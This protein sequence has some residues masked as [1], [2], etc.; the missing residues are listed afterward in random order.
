M[1]TRVEQ[2]PTATAL[3]SAGGE[4]GVG[5]ADPPRQNRQ[6][7]RN[8]LGYGCVVSVDSVSEP[9]DVASRSSPRMPVPGA[10]QY[11]PKRLRTTASGFRPA[12][13]ERH[14]TPE[15]ALSG[16]RSSL[17]NPGANRVIC[18]EIL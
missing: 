18:S 7:R 5:T 16:R 10:N 6:N 15:A 4:A 11:A 8:H 3:S 9:G 12:R 1:T 13:S 17:P 2:V 14:K